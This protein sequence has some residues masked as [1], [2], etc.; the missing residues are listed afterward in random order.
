[1]AVKPFQ[2]VDRIITKIPLAGW[3]LGGKEQSLV[4]A[5]FRVTGPLG[6]PQVAPIPLRSVGRNL[7]GIFRNLL[8]IP[9]AL[10]G[11]FEELPPQ[12]VKPDEGQKR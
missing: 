2:N 10:T 7:F 1:V 8:E 11:P 12:P 3:L 5:Y 4:V 9:E 6:D